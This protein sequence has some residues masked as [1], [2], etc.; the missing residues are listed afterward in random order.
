M[1]PDGTYTICDDALETALFSLFSLGD[2]DYREVSGSN[3]G[4]TGLRSSGILAFV[5]GYATKSL[6]RGELRSEV[7][8]WTG[9]LAI[10]SSSRQR[11][12]TS[13]RISTWLLPV[14][15]AP[16]SMTHTSFG[17]RRMPSSRR[18]TCGYVGSDRPRHRR[19]HTRASRR[20]TGGVAAGGRLSRSARWPFGLALAWPPRSSHETDQGS[21]RCHTGRGRWRAAHRRLPAI[22]GRIGEQRGRSTWRVFL[23]RPSPSIRS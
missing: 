23:S 5:T 3:P 14:E 6:D 11:S 1:N 8:A 12:L 18:V 15:P 10:P 21:R 7:T 17:Q 19:R 16:G 9:A 4:C 20:A 2:S 22:V 13:D